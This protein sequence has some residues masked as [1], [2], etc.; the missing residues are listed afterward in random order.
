MSFGTLGEYRRR[1]QRAVYQRLLM[2]GLFVAT[3]LGTASYAYQVGVSVSEAKADKVADELERFRNDNLE[4]RDRLLT[5]GERG[6]RAEKALATLEQ[7][8]EQDVPRG[9]AKVL[10]AA[11]QDQMAAGVEPERLA[12]LIDAAGEASVCSTT[13]ETKRFMPQTA[14]GDGVFGAVRFGEGRILVRGE[15]ASAQDEE[16]RAEAWFDPAEPVRLTFS[17]LEGEREDVIG[18][19]PLEHRMVLGERE[20]RFSVIP[21]ERAFVEIAVQECAL[22]EIEPVPQEDV[23]NRPDSVGPVT[24]G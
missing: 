21:G 7:R 1:R 15:G 2:V 10:F 24:S 3:L 13:P 8:Y 16:G 4:L 9:E 17:T 19:L 14:L 22:P 20:Y 23:D 5:E 11:I 12:L 6:T 18:V